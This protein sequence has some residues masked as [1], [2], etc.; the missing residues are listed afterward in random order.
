[1]I[2]VETK[3]RVSDVNKIRDKLKSLGKYEGKESKTD[4][5]YTL[6]PL[7]SY[8][9]K[10]LR[11]RKKKGFYEIN[12]KRRISYDSGIHAKKEIE[13]KASN[14]ADFILLIEDF[15]FKKW[16]RKEKETELYKIKNNFHLELNKVKGLGWFLEIEYLADENKRSIQNAE[17]EVARIIRELGVR[18]SEIVKDGYTKMLWDKKS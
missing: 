14:I 7:E 9:K 12:F 4:D 1:M 18:N 3:I 17:K 5:Y 13:F 2:E 15:G 8:P 11:I 6:E 10:S 16:L